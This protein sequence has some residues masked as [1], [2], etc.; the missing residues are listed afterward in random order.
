MLDAVGVQRPVAE[1]R[2]GLDHLDQVRAESVVDAADADDRL[3]TS[4]S[5]SCSSP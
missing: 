3:D 2:A 4:A 1:D 5:Q